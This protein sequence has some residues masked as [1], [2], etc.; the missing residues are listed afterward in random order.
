[1]SVKI[2]DID[3]GWKRIKNEVKKMRNTYVQVGV[4]SKAGDYP[5]KEAESL[6]EVATV[7][8]FGSP[9]QGIPERPFMR[10]AFDR[11]RKNITNFLMILKSLILTGK[12]DTARSMKILGEWYVGK[13]KAIFTE[14][15]FAPNA[16]A[17][18]AMAAKKAAIGRAKLEKAGKFDF[19]SKTKEKRPLID[20]GRL[21][22]SIAYEVISK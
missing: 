22:N 9:K 7:N 5:G 19:L 17:T 3:K 1:M 11:N 18:I 14:G 2:F 12:Y 16:P 8:E 13:Q 15:D 20:T 4:L 21:R 6:A 10:Q